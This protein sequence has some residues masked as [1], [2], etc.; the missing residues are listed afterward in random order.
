MAG[1][2]ARFFGRSELRTAKALKEHLHPVATTK[3]RATATYVSG[4]LREYTIQDAKPY[5]YKIVPFGG[6]KLADEISGTFMNFRTA[7]KAL[8]AYLRRTDKW[9]RAIYP[10]CQEQ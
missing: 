6:G 4:R 2:Q 1:T 3:M 8:I 10:G 5:G 9:G 7:E